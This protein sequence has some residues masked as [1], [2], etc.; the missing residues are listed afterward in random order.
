MGVNVSLQV[1][2]QDVGFLLSAQVNVQTQVTAHV[3]DGEGDFSGL[4]RRGDTAQPVS[5]EG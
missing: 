2:L 5:R 3:C 4:M 1:Y